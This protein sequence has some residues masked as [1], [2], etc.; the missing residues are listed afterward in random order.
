MNSATTKLTLA[1]GAGPFLV[2]SPNTAVSVDS[3]STQTV[4][5]SVANTN[6]APV[7]TA[8]VHITLSTDGGLTYPILLAASSAEH[9]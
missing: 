4:T 9:R 5:W 7:N 8:N 2:T 3:G 6:V 1:P